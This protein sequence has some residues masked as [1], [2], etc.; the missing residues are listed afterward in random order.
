[1]KNVRSVY[2]KLREVKYHHLTRL[3]KKY[4]K[5]TSQ[6]CKYNY[7]YKIT[8]KHEIGLCL[9]HQPEVDLSKGI[10]PNLIDVC[11][12]PEHCINCNAFINKY[13]K[14]DIKKIFEEE[15]QDQKIKSKKYPDICALEWVLEQSVIGIQPFNSLQKIYY[16]L[17]KL[18]SKRIM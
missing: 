3:Y 10:Y 13:S 17:K 1:M 12:L 7:T 16:Y 15:L 9:L 6:N 11:Y 2:Q 14:E 8:E 5:K 4:L 18:L